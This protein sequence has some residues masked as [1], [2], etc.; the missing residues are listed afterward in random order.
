ME[1]VFKTL[2]FLAIIVFIVLIIGLFLLVLKLLLLFTAQ[3][4]IFGMTIQ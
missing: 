4:N 1:K 2:F 3:I